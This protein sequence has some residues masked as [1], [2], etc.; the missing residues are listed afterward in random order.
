MG[1]LLGADKPPLPQ[2][3]FAFNDSLAIGTLRVLRENRIEVPGQVAVAGIDNLA[4]SAFI[5]PS[6][7]S[8][9]PD[10][11]EIAESALTALT[12]QIDGESGRDEYRRKLTSFELKV[13]EST[14]GS[15]AGSTQKLP[16]PGELD[17]NL[18][19]RAV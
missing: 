16:A 10:L 6:L 17:A 15:A 8:L 1:Q 18:H 3:V 7:T 5:D 12:R 13:R 19:D 9:A 14:V 11:D 2:A 4:Q